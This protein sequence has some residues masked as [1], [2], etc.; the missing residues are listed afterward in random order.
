[1]I[2]RILSELWQL[3]SLRR[4]SSTA[5]FTKDVGEAPHT[6]RGFPPMIYYLY[7]PPSCLPAGR[8]PAHPAK[9]GRG[10]L[11]STQQGIE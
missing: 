11:R 5:K 3:G 1:M 10:T 9:A 8:D 7:C 4:R 6:A 2:G